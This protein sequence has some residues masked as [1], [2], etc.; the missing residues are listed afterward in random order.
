MKL[1]AKLGLLDVILILIYTII[2]LLVSFFVP[3]Q[4]VLLSLIFALSFFIACTKISITI[5]RKVRKRKRIDL[6]R[7][8]YIII[9]VISIIIF[10]L[11]WNS[12][13]YIQAMM[14]SNIFL[15]LTTS[16]DSYVV[17][18]GEEF[19]LNS[20]ISVIKN[21]FCVAV[22][23]LTLEDLS[24]GEIIDSKNTKFSLYLSATHQ[25]SIHVDENHTG[26]KLYRL[27]LECI[28]N[29]KFLCYI[30]DTVK[31]ATK[32]ISI[33][34]QFNDRQLDYISLL[35]ESLLEVDSDY[36]M[37][38][39]NLNSIQNS[40]LDINISLDLPNI[41]KLFDL[42]SSQQFDILE[43]QLKLDSKKIPL[44]LIDLK[45][46]NR[47]IRD[48]NRFIFDLNETH[49]RIKTMS[50]LNLT[51]DSLADLNLFLDEY[52]N[53]MILLNSKND[54]STKETLLNEIKNLSRELVLNQ[55]NGT[56]VS[57]KTI[58]TFLGSPI[59]LRFDNSE[60]INKTNLLNF[61]KICCIFNECT[62]C[63]SDRTSNYPI[64]FLHGH[65]FNEQVSALGS[66]DV[67]SEIQSSLEKDGI[68]NAGSLLYIDYRSQKKEILGN[69]GRPISL[70]ASFYFDVLSTEEGTRVIETK[71]D[72]IDNYAI[73][74]KEILDNTKYITGKD[75]V[76]IV[77]HSMGGL[78]VRR[79]IQLFGESDIN[80]IIFIA[81]PHHGVDGFV[82]NYCPVFGTPK[83]CN[84]MNKGSLFLNKLNNANKISV[85]VHNI[86]GSGCFWENS[87]GDGIVKLESGKL[88]YGT[89]YIINGSCSGFN[90][91][92]VEMLKQDL[93][94]ELVELIREILL[95]PNMDQKAV[96]A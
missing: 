69:I 30:D 36:E 94:P 13:L 96:L 29:R 14:G 38:S 84:D 33:E 34:N 91:F 23:E 78:V 66:L 27:N 65:N 2:G 83:E 76:N 54:L 50:S 90:Y 26:Q 55:T 61:S 10:F 77:A 93:Y 80:K 88:D 49:N 58:L 7:R 53:R 45:R 70:R 21:P 17:K 46:I 79:Y 6:T 64:I 5:K 47:S 72:N 67:F 81:V 52:N 31:S 62:S 86:I 15:S 63:F 75:K 41:S 92:H 89:Q 73:R 56:Y 42:Y 12:S 16:Q 35:R 85:P 48:Y 9:I 82:K 37:V 51:N 1:L 60:F 39:Y 8:G 3:F 11:S 24:T 44:I 40:P 87:D 59:E 68:I 71:A 4:Y 18:N 43:G 22:C 20:E 32:I 57:N 28:T 74:L 25:F 95:N 19:L